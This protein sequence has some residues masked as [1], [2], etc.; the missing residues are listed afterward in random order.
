MSGN[1]HGKVIDGVEAIVHCFAALRLMDG[2]EK[3]DF[4][5]IAVNEDMAREKAIMNDQRLNE[6]IQG[7]VGFIPY[8]RIIEVTIVVNVPDH[9]LHY[10]VPLSDD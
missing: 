9:R 8:T 1:R 5:T 7:H 10:I 4:A 2:V 6:T 3:V